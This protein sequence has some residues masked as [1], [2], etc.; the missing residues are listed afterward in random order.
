MT[1]AART[2]LIASA[3]R[4]AQLHQAPTEVRPRAERERARPPYVALL[5][6][7]GESASGPAEPPSPTGKCTAVSREQLLA[8]VVRSDFLVDTLLR[9]PD[10]QLDAHERLLQA[11]PVRKGKWTPQEEAY[12]A[13]MIRDFRLGMLGVADGTTLRCYLAKA[14]RCDPMR[15]TK[16]FA[17]REAIGKQ[18]YRRRRPPPN[19]QAEFPDKF[20]TVK[21]QR[22]KLRHAFLVRVR[23]QYVASREPR[24]KDRRWSG[25]G[26]R[27]R[28]ASPKAPSTAQ[29]PVHLAPVGH[30]DAG[31]AGASGKGGRGHAGP[32]SAAARRRLEAQQLQ[33]KARQHP[34]VLRLPRGG[35]DGAST[36]PTSGG[37]PGHSGRVTHYASE[38]PGYPTRPAAG[39]SS[40]SSNDSQDSGTG[41]SADAGGARSLP[42]GGL[43]AAPNATSP[44]FGPS[45]LTHAVPA[46]G[47]SAA[48]CSP[49]SGV[50]AGAGAPGASRL[51][52][53]GQWRTGGAGYQTP[54][55]RASPSSSSQGRP[56]SAGP[57]VASP[58][59]IGGKKR[60]RLSPTRRSPAGI[61][62][63]RSPGSSR[64][65]VDRLI[66]R[67]EHT[68]QHH[69]GAVLL[70]QFFQSV[71]SPVP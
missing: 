41:A 34:G 6:M 1:Y 8:D 25:C 40:G 35:V 42:S 54:R 13:R 52:V 19:E 61:L 39:G 64:A 16:K 50:V 7:R 53:D 66:I 11:M 4:G 17:G 18:V 38:H 23:S 37:S 5:G 63:R 20:V 62:G 29:P 67:D 22:D 30:A 68:E 46:M 57:F 33:A 56:P 65:P 27:S 15:I 43:Y 10:A 59:I 55:K 2:A 28:K 14:L 71:N 51:D 24:S 26:P 44:P 3:T 31:N 58:G 60:R 49:R 69:E 48:G 21:I 70:T 32:R 47:V 36:S 12:T 9:G 45:S